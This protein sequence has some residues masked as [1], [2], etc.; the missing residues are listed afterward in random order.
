MRRYVIRRLLQAVVLLWLMSIGFFLLLHL[1]PGGPEAVLFSPRMTGAARAQLA[2][3]YGLDRPLV[4]QY[5]AWLGDAL[6]GNF[7]FSFADGQPVM[8][9]ISQL[10]P[11]TLELFLA[12]LLL[13]LCVAIPLGVLAAVRQYSIT[14]Y[15]TTVLSYFGLAMPVFFFAVVLQFIFGVQLHQALPIFGISSVDTTGFSP[16]DNLVD[17]GLHLILPMIV[18][19]LLFIA[20]WSRYLRSSMLDVVKQDYIRTAKAKGLAGR[21]VFFRHALRN[22]LIPMLTQVAIDFGAIFGGAVITETVFAWPG[23]GRLFYDSL[24]AR[25]Y[26]ILLALLLIGATSV[27]LFNLL[28][29][30]LY[31]VIDP[32]IRYS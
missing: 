28:A 8:H 22:A 24:Q 19:S 29:D 6:R 1:L 11:N 10:V 17:R 21:T 5:L 16:L 20:G 18:L 15:T 4:V 13:A 27:I 25:D 32:R 23:L 7:G 2:H 31:A 14:D 30:V 12:A 9:T 26:P 3:D